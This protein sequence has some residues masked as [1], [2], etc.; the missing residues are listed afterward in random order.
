MVRLVAVSMIV[1]MERIKFPVLVKHLTRP[2]RTTYRS[3]LRDRSIG[4]PD[5]Q[6]QRALLAGLSGCVS[7]I[8]AVHGW[9]RDPTSIFR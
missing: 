9:L 1:V 3:F 7:V 5:H 8:A 2:P 4:L 6:G